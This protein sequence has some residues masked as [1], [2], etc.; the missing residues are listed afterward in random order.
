MS[1]VERQRAATDT[2]AAEIER[3]E[4]AGWSPSFTRR[5]AG[6]LRP[7]LK[8]YFRSEV[9]GLD[10]FP[11][12]KALVV[13]NHSGGLFAF[14]IQ[15][16]G[17]H[18]YERFGYRRPMYTL[19]HNL[20]FTP[21]NRWFL[22]RTGFIRATHDNALQALCNGAVVVTFPGGDYDAYRP[23]FRQNVIDF[24]G[25]TGYV[26]AA[27]D[28]GAP[29]VPAVSIGLQEI[30]L[31]LARGTRLARWLG[32]KRRLRTDIFPIAFG[33]PFGFIGAPLNLP[34]P[35][36]VIIQML[37]PIDIVAEFG[38]DPDVAAVDAYVRSVMQTAL[39]G[40]GRERRWPILG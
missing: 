23:T 17:V 20:I 18:F 40:L 22:A 5:L 1:S 29:V 31:F 35:S 13:A 39:D 37:E 11:P 14:D 2:G 19:S 3:S 25:R 34:L 27:V 9:R 16:L 30:Q 10:D 36:K 6:I 8:W 15:I 21:I 24:A 38:S 32:L 4:I 12:G 26:R 7:I 28:A 33:F